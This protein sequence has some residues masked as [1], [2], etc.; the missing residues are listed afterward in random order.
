ML[1]HASAVSGLLLLVC[2]QPEYANRPFTPSKLESPRMG[3]HKT[4]IMD[5]H[6]RQSPWHEGTPFSSVIIYVIF[7]SHSAV[8]VLT[9][10]VEYSRRVGSTAPLS[11]ST[12]ALTAKPVLPPPFSVNYVI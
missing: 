12:A 7:P 9:D 2:T 8:L 4:Y 6:G 5:D 10:K 11:G 1:F 3:N